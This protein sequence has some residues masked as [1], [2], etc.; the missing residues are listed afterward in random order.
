MSIALSATNKEVQMYNNEVTYHE[1]WKTDRN[2]KFQK[3][4]MKLVAERSRC[5]CDVPLAWAEEVYELL[6]RIE[7]Q[8]GIEYDLSSFYG[9]MYNSTL[10]YLFLEAPFKALTHNRSRVPE[11]MLKY[12]DQ[13]SFFYKVKSNIA[14]FF[15]SYHYA[16]RVLYRNVKG[17]IYNKRRK[18]AVSIQ[19]VKEKFGELRIYFSARDEVSAEIDHEIRK[20]EVALAKKGAYYKLEEIYEWS[21]TRYDGE[22]KIT[23]YPYRV[24]IDG[25]RQG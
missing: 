24:L 25:R 13:R 23:T 11:H 18:P 16:F 1:V 20:V 21:T 3:K 6:S 19:Q 5:S 9:W 2:R 17:T 15:K 8:Y 14:T 22:A 10:F 7:K 12:Y 4:A